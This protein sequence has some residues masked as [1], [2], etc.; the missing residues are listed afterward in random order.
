MQPSVKSAGKPRRDVTAYKERNKTADD[1]PD[2]CAS[3]QR[4]AARTI[5]SGGIKGGEAD[6]HT[7][8]GKNDLG[9]ER[10]DGA[11]EDRSPRNAR[12]RSIVNRISGGG[13]HRSALGRYA[14]AW[15]YH[16]NWMV[17]GSR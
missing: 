2:R 8:E 13:A 6:R 9:G 11:S 3:P 16:N 14:T 15:I 1:E 4:R 12:E 10:D 5:A 7:N 17:N